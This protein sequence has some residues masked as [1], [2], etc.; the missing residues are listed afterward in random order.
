MLFGKSE[1]IILKQIGKIF[2]EEI[3]KRNFATKKDVE[4]IVHNQLSEFHANMIMP[5]LK[6]INDKVDNLS[7]E[8]VMKKELRKLYA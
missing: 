3:D 7:K 4:N 2:G 6:K 1:K 5:E 8:V